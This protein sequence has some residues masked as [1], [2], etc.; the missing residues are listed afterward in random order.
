MINSIYFETYG[1][2]ANQNNTEIMKGLV[3]QSGL[4]L[5]DNINIADILV[6]NTCIVKGKTED[7]IESRIKYF[8]KLKKPIIITGCMPDVRFKKLEKQKNIYLLS[9]RNIKQI[10]NL[11]KSIQEKRY[12]IDKFLI[13][14]KE[15]KL[16]Q[17]KIPQ[18]K[19]IG[20]TQISEGCFGNCSFCIIK[21]AKG[22]LFSYTQNNII[23]NIEN[24]LKSG[25]KEIWLTSQDNASYGQDRKKSE[26]PDLLK[27][28]LELKYN[29]R[30]RIGMMNPENIFPIL[31]ELIEIYKNEKIYKFLHMPIQSG[32]DKILK[33]MNR[34]Y[35]IKEAEL[36]IKKFREQI[37][38]LSL[39]TDLIAAFPGETESDFKQTLNLV[40]KI[41]PDTVNVSRFWAMQPTQASKLKQIPVELSK[42]RAI[43][44][45]KLHKEILKQKNQKFIGWTGKIL[46]N[47]FKNKKFKARNNSYKM[48]TLESDKDILGKFVNVKIKATEKNHFIGEVL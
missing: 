48:I 28:I 16:I 12:S 27:K 5:T 47:E 10:I 29:F 36:I 24:D 30:L 4:E 17:P 40:Q 21:L 1:C 11:I 37:P 2:S 45:K 42:Q 44:L 46:V 34:K 22:K 31:N 7:K 43:E 14:T 26:L 25:A 41:Q 39:A 33:S 8:K 15:E 18:N 6:L 35:K 13:Q 32:S 20:I 19:K 23:K 38:N 3:R 9:N